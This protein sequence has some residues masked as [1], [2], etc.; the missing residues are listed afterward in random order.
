[1]TLPHCVNQQLIMKAAR[2]GDKAAAYQALAG[3]PLLSHLAPKA[4][5]SLYDKLMKANRP[6][7]L[8]GLK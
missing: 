1:M 3:D 2:E 5:Y 7:L 4:K 6:W 8:K